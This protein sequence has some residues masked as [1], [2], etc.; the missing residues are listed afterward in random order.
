MS[1]HEGFNVPIL[2][3]MYFKVPVIAYNTC[4]IPHTLG[5]AGV[6]INKKEYEVIAEFIQYLLGNINLKEKI[7]LSQKKRLTY[8]DFDKIK[9]DLLRFINELVEYESDRFT[10]FR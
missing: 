1:E 3:S 5:N 8:F 4:A 9:D 10:Y 2:E 6:L 7:L